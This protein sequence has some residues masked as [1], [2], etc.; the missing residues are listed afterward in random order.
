[1]EIILI[2]VGMLEVLY[3]LEAI[4]DTERGAGGFGSTGK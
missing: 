2:Y 1:M 4:M 3:S